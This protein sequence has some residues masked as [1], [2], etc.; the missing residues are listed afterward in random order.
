MKDYHKKLDEL[1]IEAVI[2]KNKD[3][4][5]EK[6]QKRKD[7][8]ENLNSKANVSTRNISSRASYDNAGSVSKEE[9]EEKLRK[10]T[11][12]YNSGNAKPGSIAAKANMVKQYN[13]RNDK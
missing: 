10:A 6:A 7:Y 11:E 1:D 9:K 8:V 2:E 4:A 13:E 12:Y 3:K 5:K